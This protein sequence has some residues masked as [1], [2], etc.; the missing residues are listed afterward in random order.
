MDPLPKPKLRRNNESLK[1]NVKLF[2][3]IACEDV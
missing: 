2:S 1:R 3:D